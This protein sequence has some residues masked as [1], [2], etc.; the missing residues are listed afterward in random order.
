MQPGDDILILRKGPQGLMAILCAKAMGAGRIFAAGSGERLVK[1][2]ELG[3]IPIDY[4]V[5]DVVEK[6]KDLTN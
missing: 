4:R 6:I 3:A 1:A 2:Q 5:E